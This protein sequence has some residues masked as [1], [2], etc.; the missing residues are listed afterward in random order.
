M[1]MRK[2]IVRTIPVSKIKGY[3]VRVENGKPVAEELEPVIVVGKAN[4]KEALKA[5]QAEYGKGK[6]ITVG[7]IEVSEDT[8]EITVSDFIAHATKVTKSESNEKVETK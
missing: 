5:L 4:D 8:Y 1:A 6:A 7:E 3:T 2:T